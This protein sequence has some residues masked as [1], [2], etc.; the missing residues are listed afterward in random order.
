[1]SYIDAWSY[2]T[3]NWNVTTWHAIPENVKSVLNLDSRLGMC[4]GMLVS[5]NGSDGMREF[6]TRLNNKVK[7]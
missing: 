5:K 4:N 2:I 1:M 7:P 6:I 3:N